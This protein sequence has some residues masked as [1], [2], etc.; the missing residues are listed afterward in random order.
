MLKSSQAFPDAL[1]LGELPARAA[2]AHSSSIPVKRL[3]GFPGHRGRA[4]K[5]TLLT[6]DTNFYLAHVVSWA[7]RGWQAAEDQPL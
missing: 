3:A 6:V 2:R 5:L 4:A 7:A 1:G